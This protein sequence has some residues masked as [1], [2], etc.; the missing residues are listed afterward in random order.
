MLI[1]KDISRFPLADVSELPDDL[2]GRVKEI[3]DKM[4]F[5][6][7]IFA[8]L[9][10]RPQEFRAFFD[11]HDALMNKNCGLTKGER[12]MIVVATSSLNNCTYCVVSH[13]AIL[14]IR[15]KI[16]KLGDQIAVNFREADISVRQKA[17]LEFAVKVAKQ[18]DEICKTDFETLQSHGFS[19]D[20]IW[21]I[22]SIT[23]LFALSNRIANMAGIRPNDEFYSIGRG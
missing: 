1:H 13:G 9:A 16:P 18:A 23:A 19:E 21:D 5:I 10:H 20:D 2:Q 11:Y 8:S 4:G 17:M 12:E 6:P 7:N 14:R 22:G 15:E 3:Q